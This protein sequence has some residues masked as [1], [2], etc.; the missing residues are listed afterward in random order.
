MPVHLFMQYQ[1]V[2]SEF[3]VVAGMVVF[4]IKMLMTTPALAL[5][6]WWTRGFA[7]S[8]HGSVAV[9]QSVAQSLARYDLDAAAQALRQS[10]GENAEALPPELRA[11]YEELL[12]NLATYKAYLPG[13]IPLNV[14]PSGSFTWIDFSI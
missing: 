8:L 4:I 2:D 13:K 7:T 14:F 1:V 12:H 5:D 6:F 10:D 11:A 3:G 9:A